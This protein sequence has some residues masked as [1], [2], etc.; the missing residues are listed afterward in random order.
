MSKSKYTKKQDRNE[1]FHWLVNHYVTYNVE[2]IKDNPRV[3]SE[4]Y[5]KETNKH[6]PQTTIY[7]WFRRFDV[8]IAHEYEEIGRARL[9]IR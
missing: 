8:Y 2:D 1:F 4:T 9:S 3:I 5:Y 7:R 6:I